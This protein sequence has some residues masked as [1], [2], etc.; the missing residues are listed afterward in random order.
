[1]RKKIY[2]LTV[3]LSR[4]LLSFAGQSLNGEWRFCFVDA[5]TLPD[6][7]SVFY[8]PGYDDSRW[9]HIAVPGNWEI[10]GKKKPEYG[11]EVSACH[12][13]YRTH[14]AT[15]SMKE[16]ERLVLRT[17]GVLFAY[18]LYVN[19]HHAGY[20]AAAFCRKEW[21]IT[22]FLAQDGNNTLAMDVSTRSRDNAYRFDLNDCWALTGIF[23]DVTL[24]TRPNRHIA[25]YTFR[26][27]VHS[28]GSATV[29][30]RTR[31]HA[32]LPADGQCRTWLRDHRGHVVAKGD[33]VL[34]ASIRKPRLWSAE[35]PYLY[36]LSIE[37]TDGN[38]TTDRRV[39]KVG[40]REI[41]IAG[42]TLLLNNRPLTLRGVCMN[43][44]HP[45]YGRA[46][47]EHVLRE[48]LRLVKQA[49]INYIRTAHYPFQPLF[50]RLCDEMGLYVVCEVPFGYGDSNLP[51]TAYLPRL[52][53]RAD[54]TVS[55]NKNHPSV[56]IWS[57][58]NE[59]PYTYIVEKTIEH[60]RDI[61]PTRPR[62]IPGY[63]VSNAFLR[64]S[65]TSAL[66][67]FALHYQSVE[68]IE[69][70]AGYHRKPIILTE[71]AHAL[72]LA[73]DALE[74]QQ[75][76]IRRHAGIA[77]GSVW[78]WAD[79]AL[80][81][82]RTA[83]ECRL[84]TIPQGVWLD[85]TTYYDSYTDKGTDGIVFANRYPQEDYF[86]VRKLYSPIWVDTDS[87]LY[88]DGKGKTR[89][90][91]V[92]ENRHDFLSLRH[93][94]CHWRITDGREPVASG[95]KRLRALPAQQE[96]L[97]ISQ[98]LSGMACPL[99]HLCFTSPAGDT[100]YE[101]N[102]RL[103]PSEISRQKSEIT[104]T[105][106]A[107]SD[108]RRRHYFQNGVLTIVSATGDTL[109]S[110][111]LLLRVGRKPSI[112][113]VNL[114]QRRKLDSYWMPYIIAPEILSCGQQWEGSEAVYTVHARWHRQNTDGEEYYEGLITVKPSLEGG[115]SIAYDIHSRHASG[116][117][118]ELG[119]TLRMPE[120][121]DTFAWLGKGPYSSTPH[122]S[123]LNETD[124]WFL[125]KEDMRLTGNRAQV[126]IAAVV[127]SADTN[128]GV[129]LV[130]TSDLGAEN[131][132]GALYLTDTRLLSSYGTK[133]SRMMVQ[134]KAH[135][136]KH[137]QGQILVT[138]LADNTAARRL[139][140]PLPAITPQKPFL[141]IYDH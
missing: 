106:S 79:Q 30:C 29:D 137:A 71:Y 63:K 33:T 43:E 22:P 48:D 46:I 91:F 132:G 133:L 21:D 60:V 18:D 111:P 13:L 68:K 136:A 5:P 38:G 104:A 103:Q 59:N 105:G 96:T 83:E 2:I 100:I 55:L 39:E 93:F 36:T 15:P 138:P 53:E 27:T 69:E 102:I 80:R 110:S 28:D 37:Y 126:Q 128:D 75:A 49:N 40:I 89:L 120:R 52:I 67:L 141:K 139:F 34:H 84:D 131:I 77:G 72:G 24:L 122:K 45:E 113:L 65:T 78:V 31:I 61:D 76:M 7:L 70:M 81:R 9:D 16:G 134:Q 90:S 95:I 129:A 94:H 51:D 8:H 19:G 112:N 25:D 62:T 107:G 54:A 42:D 57:V 17:D 127:N 20:W 121:Y 140:L 108:L 99:L 123:A 135:Q 47:P 115:V 125:D 64:D 12:G 11:G 86:Q 124:I 82:T 58:G 85:S 23:R 130:P 14:F 109:L 41:R 6:S 56:I 117:I 87:L 119:L 35:D 50:F 118:L 66:S 73:F 98:R 101:H 3:F 97:T 32:P 10:A 116:T 4:A 114:I 88:H 1:M 74:S 44:L 26:S 92:V